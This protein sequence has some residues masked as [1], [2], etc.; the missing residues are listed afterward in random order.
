[1]S[2]SKESNCLLHFRDQRK[3][4]KKTVSLGLIKGWDYH[5]SRGAELRPLSHWES[6]RRI[7]D[8]PTWNTVAK[9]KQSEYTAPPAYT[10]SRPSTA[11]PDPTREDTLPHFGRLYDFIASEVTLGPTQGEQTR[12]VLPIFLTVDNT[13]NVTFTEYTQKQVTIDEKG[14]TKSVR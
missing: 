6:G 13:G 3:D 11:Y 1:M 2:T 12:L 8:P 9:Y 7:K 4:S 5:V 10:D 14:R